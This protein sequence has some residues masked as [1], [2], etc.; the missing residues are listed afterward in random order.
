MSEENHSNGVVG[1]P[2]NGGLAEAR[3]EETHALR[4]RKA[5]L[6][7]SE[8]FMD[9]ADERKDL[10]PILLEALHNA[11]DNLLVYGEA[12]DLMVLEEWLSMEEESK[13]AEWRR[14]RS[15]LDRRDYDRRFADRRFVDRRQNP[16][17]LTYDNREQVER[18]IAQR[19]QQRPNGDRRQENRRSPR[20]WQFED[21]KIFDPF[22]P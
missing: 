3:Y 19:R 20:D 7:L 8:A 12:G 10:S 18:R 22:Q 15:E 5:I 16:A 4:W 17:S 21:I 14:E 9:A 1:L 2:E 11:L 13:S 6:R